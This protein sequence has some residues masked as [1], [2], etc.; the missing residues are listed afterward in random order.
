MAALGTATLGDPTIAG[1]TVTAYDSPD[2]GVL[3]DGNV[4]IS[5]AGGAGGF[6]VPE[7]GIIWPNGVNVNT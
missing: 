4:A 7:V 5:E 3:L 1:L 2:Y 6:D